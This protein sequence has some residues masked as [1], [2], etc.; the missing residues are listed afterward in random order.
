[1]V[2]FVAV[3]TVTEL[4]SVYCGADAPAVK[5]YVDVPKDKNVVAPEPE[6]YASAP[7][8]PP[9]KLVAVPTAKED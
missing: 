2:A 9:A 3:P 4:G 7:A 5:I 1:M 6:L 8:E